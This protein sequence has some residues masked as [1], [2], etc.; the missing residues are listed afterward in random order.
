MPEL[1]GRQ[2]L[3]TAVALNGAGFNLARAVGPA[4]GGFV[5]AAAGPGAV[6]LLNAVSFLAVVWVIHRWERPAEQP[7]EESQ[8][9]PERVVDAIQA[10]GR[11]AWH[12]PELRSVNVRT[13]ACVIAASS[14]WALIPV[15]ATQDLGLSA[16]GYGVLLGSIGFGAVGGA[17][18]MPGLRDRFS[19]GWIVTGSAV[20]FA[21]TILAL[22]YV[23]N[24]WLLNGAMLVTGATWLI[25]TSA[26]NVAAQTTVPTWV[27]ARALGAYLLV[28]QGC[29][30]AG[31][32]AWGAVAARLG[33]STAL[34][35]A[36]ALLVAGQVVALRWRIRTGEEMDLSPSQHW[37]HPDVVVEPEPQEGPVLITIEYHVAEDQDM[38]FVEAMQ[39]VRIIRLRD[40]ATR[41]DLFVDPSDPSRYVEVFIVPSW[42]EHLRQ[43]DRLTVADRE[44]EE[45]ALSLQQPGTS[46][47][48][49][50]LVAARPTSVVVN[51]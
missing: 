7:A 3:A 41:W 15:V 35:V 38:N 47:V 34:L 51:A 22:G 11:Y 43:H 39:D 8:S 50:H 17:F 16:T 21:A 30:A 31:S 18:V 6:F 33:N 45:R 26:L 36:A 27:Q 13:A 40:G 5:V 23:R 24:L 37:E 25:L 29:F 14:L 20:V 32:A 10:G 4:L 46:P 1:V 49:N 19:I 12:S 44:V 9:P 28:F 42:A 48:A 2:Q